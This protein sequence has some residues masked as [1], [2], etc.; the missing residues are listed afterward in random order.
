[1][2]IYTYKSPFEI[3]KMNVWESI[4]TCPHLCVS[5]TLVEGLKEYYG[6][7][8]FTV[9]CTI[10]SMLKVLYKDWHDDTENDIE[11]SVKISDAIRKLP[12]QPLKSTFNHNKQDI[13]KAIRYLIESDISP[14]V[15]L[16]GLPTEQQLFLEVYKQVA[17]NKVFKTL[18]N[19]KSTDIEEFHKCCVEILREEL[20][21]YITDQTVLEAL[22]KVKEKKTIYDKLL[23]ETIDKSIETIKRELQE[24]SRRKQ[25]NT[26]VL[27]KSERSKDVNLRIQQG[28][29]R[30]KRIETVKKLFLQ[31]RDEAYLLDY[32]KVVIHGVHQ[33]TPLI[34]KLV[35]DLEKMGLEVV[36]LFNY[37]SEYEEIYKTWKN[38]YEWVNQGKFIEEG[39]EAQGQDYLKGRE[40]GYALA[41]V[42]EGD[43]AKV[44]SFYDVEYTAFDNLTSFSDYVSQKYKPA[45]EKVDKKFGNKLPPNHKLLRLAGM[46]EQFYAIN[47]TQTNELLKIYFPEQFSSRHFLSYPVGQFIR[48]L[49]KMWDVHKETINITEEH[50]KE[51]LALHVWNEEGK[52]TPLE[53]FYNLKHC[54]K[55]KTDFN[56]YL[57]V[58]ENI[59]AIVGGAKDPRRKR[60]SFF[61][62]TP[63]EIDYFTQVIKDIKLI[64][65][66]LFSKKTS[67]FRKHYETLIKRIL[68]NETIS[69]HISQDEL[70]FVEDIKK[71]ISHLERSTEQ[72]HIS[73]IKE[74]IVYYLESN[75]NSMYEA[76]WIV[77]DFEQIDGGV[78]LAEAQKREDE[79][80]EIPRAEGHEKVF[81]YAGLSD[82]NMLGKT[83][84][85]LPWPLDED[86]FYRVTSPIAEICSVCRSE[87]NYFLRYSLFYGT[88]FLTD[89]KKIALSYIKNLGDKEASPYSTLS[90]INIK[91]EDASIDQDFGKSKSEPNYDNNKIITVTMP[92]TD[93]EKRSMRACFK[94]YLFNHCLDQDTYFNDDYYLDQICKFFI[95]YAYIR[96]HRE[97]EHSNKVHEPTLNKLFRYFPF[98]LEVDKAEIKN[99]IQEDLNKGASYSSV[100]Q[101]QYIDSKMEF[102]YR[103]WKVQDEENG[104]S[105]IDLFKYFMGKQSDEEFKQVFKKFEKFV[106]DDE[107]F[108]KVEEHKGK[109]CEV[110]NQRYLCINTKMDK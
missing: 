12:D 8:E 60:M 81:H 48:S 84:V 83:K 101:Q 58:L 45:S 14:N 108:V 26:I 74:T 79:E 93:S 72:V 4:R 96:R 47:G 100:S 75:L 94:R 42:Y 63:D 71:H 90:L 109:V 61:I 88:Y 77:R 34:L 31:Y 43:F 49:Y 80:N 22:H 97:Q 89:R 46:H 9:L 91:P 36:F 39:L 69:S 57:E 21:K 107:E 15:D 76:E 38:V 85:Q 67:P 5:Q 103:A 11:Q 56:G 16:S 52:P 99:A 29:K 30:L 106:E 18:K 7:E 73:D 51:A 54:F 70:K 62:Y 53:M 105:E 98:F 78:L 1:M 17:G 110:C 65:E 59:K 6:R 10:D 40:L 25:K 2:K 13:I 32:S 64:A 86:L 27:L 66:S 33:F 50:I 20:K 23:L 44:E 3:T 41:S 55:N 28:K 82:E 87:Y 68:G 102:I 35:S 92:E 37:A 104:N 19:A 95:R 24:D